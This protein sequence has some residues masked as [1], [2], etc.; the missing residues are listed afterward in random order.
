ME[1]KDLL[2]LRYHEFGSQ[3]PGDE[4]NPG[5]NCHFCID[6]VHT[7]YSDLNTRRVITEQHLNP[8]SIKDLC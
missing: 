1:D 4:K 8:T 6:L 3:L 2:I 7:Q 5:T